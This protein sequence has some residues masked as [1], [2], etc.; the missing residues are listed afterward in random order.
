MSIFLVGRKMLG[1]E[2][3]YGAI[4]SALLLEFNKEFPGWS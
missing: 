4:R 2:F 3:G 1:E